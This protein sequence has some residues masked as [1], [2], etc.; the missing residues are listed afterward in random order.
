[1][2]FF[3]FVIHRGVS[4]KHSIP[5]LLLWPLWG[6]KITSAAE[7]SNLLCVC[8]TCLLAHVCGQ[9]WRTRAEVLVAV[10]QEG[11]ERVHPVGLLDHRH[12]VGLCVDKKEKSRWLNIRPKHFDTGQHLLQR[13]YSL[14]YQKMS[15]K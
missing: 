14:F 6:K 11:R 15:T 8:L 1:M 9:V 12:F 7:A 2:S 5:L 13:S 10:G 4:P 3:H